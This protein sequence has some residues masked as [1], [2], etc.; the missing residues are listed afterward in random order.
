MTSSISL[1]RVASHSSDGKP[2][3]PPLPIA[4][5]PPGGESARPIYI[6]GYPV[7][8]SDVDPLTRVAF[9]GDPLAKR[10][11]PGYL[12]SVIP[13][14]TTFLHDCFT[15]PGN[16]GSPIVDLQIGQVIGSHLGRT[17]FGG[18]GPGL[19]NAIAL[20]MLKGHKLMKAAGVKFS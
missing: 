9:D 13:S 2:L 7:A 1:V 19:R 11:Q 5:E 4:G 17:T 15:M 14:E 8:S 12:L 16:G 18:A 6:V 3:P 20:W 10:V